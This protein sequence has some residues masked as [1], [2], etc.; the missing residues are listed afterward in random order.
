MAAARLERAGDHD[1]LLERHGHH[2]VLVDEVA[3][4]DLRKR[5]AVG[6]ARREDGQRV[7]VGKAEQHQH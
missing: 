4:E 2:G 7:V 6:G 5:G 3:E 1:E